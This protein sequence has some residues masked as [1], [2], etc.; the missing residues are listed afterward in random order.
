ML[1]NPGMLR[2]LKRAA[3]S[4]MTTPATLPSGMTTCYYHP[5][6]NLTNLGSGI[7]AG[8]PRY[9][10][11]FRQEVVVNVGDTAILGSGTWAMTQVFQPS[12]LEDDT[13]TL[14]YAY[15]LTDAAGTPL[16]LRPNAT[17]NV[18]RQD[19]TAI[20]NGTGRRV[21]LLNPAEAVERVLASGGSIARWILDTPEADYRINDV[22][23]LTQLDGFASPP[24]IT[25]LFVSSID[26]ASSSGVSWLEIGI[27]ANR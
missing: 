6:K 16:Y 27:S 10:F 5:D 25:V 9:K 21:R 2:S 17:I 15:Q 20:T 11:L 14:C 24:D 23:T 1:V 18:T 12:T 19:S 13:H 8:L 3:N 26:P 22:V 4:A 7:F